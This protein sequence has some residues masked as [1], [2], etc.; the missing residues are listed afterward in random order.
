MR[1]AIASLTLRLPNRCSISWLQV[2]VDVIKPG[3]LLEVELFETRAV[4]PL[5]QFKDPFLAAL[6]VGHP[7][8]DAMRTAALLEISRFVKSAFLEEMR[9]SLSRCFLRTKLVQVLARLERTRIP[10][11]TR[12]LAALLV[13]ERANKL[14]VLVETHSNIE[15]S[16]SARSPHRGRLGIKLDIGIGE[17]IRV[18][19]HVLVLLVCPDGGPDDILLGNAFP[20]FTSQQLPTSRRCKGCNIALAI[21]L[22]TWM[23]IRMLE[24]LRYQ[25]SEVQLTYKP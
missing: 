25:D 4:V 5:P 15:D 19:G 21:L 7:D 16:G 1:L 3:V 2:T 6:S 20:A 23:A 18:H 8:L 10:S 22:V 9:Q 12:I 17:K 24:Q 11:F 13:V 14:V